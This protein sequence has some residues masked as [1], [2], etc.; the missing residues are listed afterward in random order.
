MMK[1]IK[2]KATTKKA[3]MI[4]QAMQVKTNTNTMASTSM[5]TVK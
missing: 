1:M 5:E 4:M 3:K 2:M